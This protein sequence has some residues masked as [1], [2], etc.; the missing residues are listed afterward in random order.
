VRALVLAG[1][2]LRERGGVL[3]LNR[4]QPAVLRVLELL[5]ADQV[6]QVQSAARGRVEEGAREA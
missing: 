5:G 3:V 6:I 2:A 4:P 1:K